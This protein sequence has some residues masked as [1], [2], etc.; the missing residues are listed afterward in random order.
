M[1]NTAERSDGRSHGGDAHPSRRGRAG[2]GG[3]SGFRDPT[4]TRRARETRQS[5][6]RSQRRATSN[7]V[8]RGKPEHGGE[9]RAHGWQRGG[10]ITLGRVLRPPIPA[11]MTVEIISST[12]RTPENGV[13]R[14]IRNRRSGRA[15]SRRQWQ[16]PRQRTNTRS[17]QRD[18]GIRRF[19]RRTRPG[20]DSRD[21]AV[22]YGLDHGAGGQC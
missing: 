10:R 18:Q 3:E 2:E 5:R 9:L 19:R 20:L 14:G 22:R 12:L 16:Q 8:W 11:N 21:Q 1:G 4:L 7:R 17:R 6:R 15:R 13:E